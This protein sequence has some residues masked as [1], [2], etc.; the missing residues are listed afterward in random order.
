[1]I[2]L[3][4]RNSKG[5]ICFNGIIQQIDVLRNISNGLMPTAQIVGYSGPSCKNVSGGRFQN[6]KDQICQCRLSCPGLADECSRR[7]RPNGQV[8]M[9]QNQ[10]VSVWITV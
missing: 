10:T 9:I 1:M 8:Q 2:N 5:N 4:L 3:F 7:I 6:A